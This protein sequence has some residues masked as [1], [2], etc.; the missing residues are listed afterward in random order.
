M[1]LIKLCRKYLES[2]TKIKELVLSS[3]QNNVLPSISM[4]KQNW[5]KIIASID[6]FSKFKTATK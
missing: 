1:V 5:I 4:A 3:V 2:S 6:R